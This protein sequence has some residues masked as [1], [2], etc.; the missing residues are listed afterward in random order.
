MKYAVIVLAI[1]MF[2]ISAASASSAGQFLPR[3]FFTLDAEGHQSDVHPVNAHLLRR[4]RRQ[5]Y[6]A[7]S[8]SS[9]SSSSSGNGVTFASTSH[10]IQNADGSGSAGSSY[11]Q[12]QAAPASVGGVSFESRFGEDSAS[13]Q[14][15][16]SYNTGA[17]NGNNAAYN[18]NPASYNT[19]SSVNT[20]TGYGSTSNYQQSYG[21]GAVPAT[22]IHQTVTTF[23]A[24]GNQKVTTVQGATDETGV[25]NVQKTE[26]H[27]S[28]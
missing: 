22:Q 4:L 14:Y 28:G 13:G 16:P 20:N 3:A 5:V 27:Y 24:N 11:T 8:S 17:Y 19:A 7:S 12:Q 25:L 6:S 15:N 9:S 18:S 21:S 1:A 10:T 2:A 23:D 26:A